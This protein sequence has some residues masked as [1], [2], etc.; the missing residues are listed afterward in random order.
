MTALCGGGP[1][2]PKSGVAETIIYTTGMLASL[3]NNRGGLWASVAAPLLGV[4]AYDATALCGIDPPAKPTISAEEYTA[5]LQLAPWDT[6]QVALGKLKDLLTAAI[7]YEL[8]ECSSGTR[9]PMPPD[10]L[11]PPAGVSVGPT[12]NNCP[13]VS[14]RLMVPYKADPNVM[15]QQFNITRAL[16][17]DLP[18]YQSA[19]SPPNWPPQDMAPIPPNWTGVQVELVLVGNDCTGSDQYSV[20]WSTLEADGT[21]M[22]FYAWPSVSPLLRY[23]TDPSTHSYLLLPR[24]TGPYFAVHA[25]HSGSCP[26]QEVDVVIRHTCTPGVGLSTCCPPDPAV[27]SML[28]QLLQLATLEQ[29]WRLPF[30]TIDGA[31]TPASGTGSF[32]VSRAV[33]LRIEVVTE[34]PGTRTSFGNPPYHFDLGWLS[35]T[36]GGGMLQEVRVTR[37]V[38]TWF[39]AQMQLATLV[40][41]AL[42]PGVVAYITELR[43]EA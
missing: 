9:P 15:S 17:P 27:V 19:D 28:Q 12:L 16:Y 10:L 26:D 39:P 13:Q 11:T 42:K 8:C 40:G 43:V 1:S 37:P 18:I 3:L 41:Y 34:P 6:L 35:V 20:M 32:A 33:G 2:G 24:P 38:Q 29:R 22:G 21:A 36:D 7:W 30:G 23:Y 5:L 25:W 4:L 31:T 14:A